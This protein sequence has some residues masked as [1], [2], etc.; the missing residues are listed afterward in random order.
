MFSTV[1]SKGS[2]VLMKITN[3]GPAQKSA[4]ASA[5]PFKFTV[6]AKIRYIK[7]AMTRRSGATRLLIGEIVVE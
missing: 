2:N 6:N 7:A 4:N 3:T 1:T 5:L